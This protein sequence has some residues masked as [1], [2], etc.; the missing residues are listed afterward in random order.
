MKLKEKNIIHLLFENE[1]EIVPGIYFVCDEN[2]EVRYIGQSNNIRNRLYK[3]NQKKRFDEFNSTIF[4]FYNNNKEDRLKLEHYYL[5]KYRPSL[6]I[7]YGKT[8]VSIRLYRPLLNE[9]DK[10]LT[11]IKN[12]T[13]EAITFTSLVETAMIRFVDY[14]WRKRKRQKL[15]E[16]K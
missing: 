9:I 16:E 8:L 3:H 13:G 15:L 1:K 4:Y 12:E 14:Y 6:N 2:R 5:A 11:D 7:I 10:I